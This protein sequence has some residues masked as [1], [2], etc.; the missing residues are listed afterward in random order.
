MARQQSPR[1]GGRRTRVARR[2]P[3]TASGLTGLTG[4]FGAA[5]WDAEVPSMPH[6]CAAPLAG[7][8]VVLLFD[9]VPALARGH[10]ASTQT[11]PVRRS[12][13]SPRAVPPKPPT[14]PSASQVPLV[15]DHTEIPAL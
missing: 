7:L 4:R 5:C 14:P 13:Q 10:A 1:M 3:A 12:V 15:A 2:P 11:T 6:K 8:V 9:P